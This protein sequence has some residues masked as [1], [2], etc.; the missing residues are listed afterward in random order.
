MTHRISIRILLCAALACAWI[1]HAYASGS[2]GEGSQGSGDSSWGSW[3]WGW[4]TGDVADHP[5]TDFMDPIKEMPLGLG[6][7]ASIGGSMQYRF[8]ELHDRFTFDNDPTDEH[9]SLLAR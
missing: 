6:F 4:Q 1:P 9:V 2:G 3:G 8:Q 5:F 7:N